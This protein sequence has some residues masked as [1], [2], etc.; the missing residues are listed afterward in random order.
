MS[1]LI[2]REISAN[3]PDI[4][5]KNN[6]DKK[7]IVI[8]VAIPSDKNTSTKVSKKISKYKEIKLELNH[9]GKLFCQFRDF[10]SLTVAHSS[11][12][13]TKQKRVL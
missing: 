9:L 2:D 1:I 5:I 12:N 13:G 11:R 4:V 10:C 7:C 3:R 6:R 8:N